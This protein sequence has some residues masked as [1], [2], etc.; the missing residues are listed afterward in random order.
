MSSNVGRYAS[1][2][3]AGQALE[4]QE[5]KMKILPDEPEQ[6][7]NTKR[8]AET[9]LTG[10]AKSAR[11]DI[12]HNPSQVDNPLFDVGSSPF[13]AVSTRGS[14]SNRVV[15]ESQAALGDY[16]GKQRSEGLPAEQSFLSE[17]TSRQTS[18][19]VV[20]PGSSPYQASSPND[21][22][23]FISRRV[24][25]ESD[26]ALDD[27]LAERGFMKKATKQKVND[28]ESAVTCV[29]KS[30]LHATHAAPAL[31]IRTRNAKATV[32]YSDDE[33]LLSPEDGNIFYASA[34]T[35]TTPESDEH[36]IRKP[37]RKAATPSNRSHC[38]G[39]T[40]INHSRE[41]RWEDTS[42]R[43]K[44]AALIQRPKRAV[45]AGNGVVWDSMIDPLWRL[46]TGLVFAAGR[47]RKAQEKA[48]QESIEAM[49]SSAKSETKVIKR[50]AVAKTS[51]ST[52]AELEAQ[53]TPLWE[54]VLTVGSE[55]ELFK[56]G[57]P[58]LPLEDP[59]AVPKPEDIT[60]YG[61]PEAVSDPELWSGDGDE[62]WE[63]EDEE[64]WW[65]ED[66]VENVCVAGE[67]P[68]LQ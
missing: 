21:V 42:V 9:P 33:I 34:T 49:L 48:E 15:S 44:A 38:S 10:L 3:S 8:N 64:Q 68:E 19:H 24:V 52:V 61:F 54:D 7:A 43:K 35:A 36:L 4:G 47:R 31:V 60:P 13:Q 11:T 67:I 18:R 55:D 50:K 14:I 37:S 22:N 1:G 28:D 25:L 12:K 16:I 17:L 41:L 5:K 57:P 45:E 56:I 58:P 20:H 23:V 46:D 26:A 2:Y 40:A 66:Y 62:Y 30:R 53:E 39:W 51:E 6:V 27:F 32:V 63:G 59:K 65:E 29:D